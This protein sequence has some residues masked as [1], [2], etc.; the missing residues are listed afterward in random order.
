MSRKR[1]YVIVIIQEFPFSVVMPDPD[2]V[3]FIEMN[4]GNAVSFLTVSSSMG[5][6]QHVSIPYY[7]QVYHVRRTWISVIGKNKLIVPGDR[8]LEK[9]EMLVISVTNVYVC[10]L[11]RYDLMRTHIWV[12]PLQYRVE[13]YW[14][15]KTRKKYIKIIYIFC[16]IMTEFSWF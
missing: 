1:R 3:T 12:G 11:E 2:V 8:R 4:H 13:G 15:C 7:L 9:T 16:I 5:S 6:A 14:I 10:I